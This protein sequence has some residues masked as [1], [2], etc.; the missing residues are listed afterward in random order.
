MNEET[1]STLQAVS[2]LFQNLSTDAQNL[3]S[4]VLEIEQASLHLKKPRGLKLKVLEL[5]RNIIS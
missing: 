4:G 1:K 2:E 3:V 5:V